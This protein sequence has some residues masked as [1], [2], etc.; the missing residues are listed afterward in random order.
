MISQPEAVTDVIF[1]AIAVTAS[2]GDA[3]WAEA[4]F[5]AYLTE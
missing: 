5:E 2:P 4:F 1:Q 3:S